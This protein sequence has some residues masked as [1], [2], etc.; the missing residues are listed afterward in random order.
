MSEMRGFLFEVPSL[1]M[2]SCLYLPL[3]QQLVMPGGAAIWTTRD[4]MIAAVFQEIHQSR[5]LVVLAQLRPEQETDATTLALHAIACLALVAD[6]R[7]DPS[8]LYQITFAG[9]GRV[10]LGE[11]HVA[12]G[13][14]F[15]RVDVSPVASNY[16]PEPEARERLDRFSQ[17]IA[18]LGAAH[19]DA[20]TALQRYAQ[21]DADVGLISDR[22]AG[23][24]SLHDSDFLRR[25]LDALDVTDRM[26]MMEEQS[27]RFIAA[28]QAAVRTGPLD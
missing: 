18:S 15:A 11:R 27:L 23:L 10:R 2:Q 8:G 1:L 17:M 24:V 7:Q 3:T 25:A 9:I 21:S 19:P 6:H 4:P 14:A 22:L 13:Q 5:E 20:A 12:P 28:L 16:P 26:A